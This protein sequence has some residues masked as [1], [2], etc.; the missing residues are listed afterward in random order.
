[1]RPS[2]PVHHLLLASLG[3][4][5]VMT[6]GNRASEPT[7]IDDAVAMTDLATIADVLL[8]NDRPIVAP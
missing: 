4:P 2:T 5:L 1:M 8:S 3:R 6:S 7:L